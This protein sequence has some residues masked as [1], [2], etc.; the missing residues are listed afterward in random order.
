[1]RRHEP[2]PQ[3][4]VSGGWKVTDR[5]LKEHKSSCIVRL[6]KGATRRVW[7]PFV[8]YFHR[9]REPPAPGMVSDTLSWNR[10]WGRG[11]PGAPG[12]SGQHAGSAP[13]AGRSQLCSRGSPL[14]LGLPDHAGDSP[15]LSRSG[16]EKG[17]RGS[18]AGTL[19]VPLGGTRRVDV[20][21]G[22]PRCVWARESTAPAQ[23]NQS[24]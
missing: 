22:L 18:G 2:E 15:L 5:S 4:R 16:G 6:S 9:A 8:C 24:L 10:A 23:G 7:P 21:W 11:S 1:M 3:S 13:G 14:Q 12:G 17:L 19:G 20:V